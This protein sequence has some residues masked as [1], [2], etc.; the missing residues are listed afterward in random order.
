MVFMSTSEFDPDV[1]T[2]RLPSAP[3]L[4]DFN[5]NGRP[6]ELTLSCNYAQLEA[7]ASAAAEMALGM[8]FVRALEYLLWQRLGVTITWLHDEMIIDLPSPTG[9]LT[10]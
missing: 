1:Q 6:R 10:R 7:Q 4:I 2:G 9:R 5:R 3:P 8:S